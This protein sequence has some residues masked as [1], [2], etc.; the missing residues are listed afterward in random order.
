MQKQ[1]SLAEKR[2]EGLSISMVSSYSLGVGLDLSLLSRRDFPLV[3]GLWRHVENW[4]FFTSKS[5]CWLPNEDPKI[6]TYYHS[7][8][9]S[10]FRRKIWS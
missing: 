2:D 7:N 1:V 6:F 4:I 3:L 9:L 8:F 10:E 5:D